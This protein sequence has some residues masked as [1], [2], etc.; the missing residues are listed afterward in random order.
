MLPFDSANLNHYHLGLYAMTGPLQM[1]AGIKPDQ[2]LLWFSQFL[3]GL[4]GVGVFLFLDRKVSRQAGF[5]GIVK[6]WFV[7]GFSFMVRQ[8]GTL[9]PTFCS[10]DPVACGFDHLGGSYFH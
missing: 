3:N 4:C 5:I 8:L 2:A 10:N 6:R 9:H 7:F 1:L